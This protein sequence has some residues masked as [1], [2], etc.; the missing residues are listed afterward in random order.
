M[1]YYAIVTSFGAAKF[2]EMVS[3]GQ[4]LVLQDFAVGDGNGSVYDPVATQT[5]L[6]RETYRGIINSLIVD[7]NNDKQVIAECLVPENSG[8]WYIRELGI[9]DE[10]GDLILIAKY[11][12]TYKP[13]PAD[14]ALL[15]QFTIKMVMEVGSPDNV[16]L[17]IEAGSIATIEYVDNK[18]ALLTDSTVVDLSN[19]DNYLTPY[20]FANLRATVDK[21]GVVELANDLE[22]QKQTVSDKVI[23]PASIPG[24]RATLDQVKAGVENRFL[25]AAILLQLLAATDQAG[26]T[27]LATDALA[28]AMTSDKTVLT[29]KNLVALKATLTE[30]KAASANRLISPDILMQL[31]ATTSQNGLVKLANGTQT[32]AQTAS[33][34]VVTPSGL[35]SLIATLA[36]VQAG[37][38]AVKYITPA[39]LA[40]VVSNLG[41]GVGQTW[42]RRTGMTIGTTYTNTTGKPIVVSA[43]VHGGSSNDD[44]YF[45][46]TPSSDAPMISDVFLQAGANNRFSLLAIVPPSSTYRL[47]S[48]GWAI[49][50]IW[51]ELR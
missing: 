40:S 20:G 30:L 34:L 44:V 45:Y 23:T 38:N 46:I 24:L 11:P 36:E 5:A 37:S 49:L 39:T 32:A 19:D 8:G 27:T 7:P 42:Q 31:L 21:A 4:Q 17:S 22:V 6:R 9:F 29:P 13:S 2:A 14:G 33:D 51:C 26:L 47:T 16:A 25:T 15:K 3:N 10:A 43:T 48:S 41:L 50:D 28:Q 35:A 18:K 12:E 1:S